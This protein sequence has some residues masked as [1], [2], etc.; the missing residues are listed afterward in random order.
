MHED[1]ASRQTAW[2]KS[3][4]RSFGSNQVDFGGI[5]APASAM[6]IIS[7]TVTGYIENATAS[8]PSATRS[9]S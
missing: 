2:T 6:A 4:D 3:P 9:W 8:R 7:P 5:T 1:Y